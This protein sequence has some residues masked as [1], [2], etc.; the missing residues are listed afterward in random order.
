MTSPPNHMGDDSSLRSDDAASHP[1]LLPCPF[2]G[3]NALLHEYAVRDG[4]SNWIE[5][6]IMCLGNDCNVDPVTHTF[7]NADEAIAAW[8]SRAPVT[9]EAGAERSEATNNPA[10]RI[11]ALEEAL[12]KCAAQFRHYRNQH[13]A[14]TPPDYEK[15]ATNEAF[16]LMIDRA[17]CAEGEGK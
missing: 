14:K 11:T 16:A 9:T 8:N 15:A 17:L 10:D 4:R 12:R 1:A 3:E 13:H 6:R 5:Y 7:S 2:C